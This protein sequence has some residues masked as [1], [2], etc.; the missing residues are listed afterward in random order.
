[1]VL[2]VIAHVESEPVEGAVVR[3]RLLKLDEHIVLGDEV[4]RHRMK[5]HTC[6]EDTEDAMMYT[7]N[8]KAPFE[9]KQKQKKN[10]RKVS[11]RATFHQ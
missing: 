4:T 5:S 3:V 6:T 8:K 1:M 2:V 11:Y 9:E 7:E 10:V